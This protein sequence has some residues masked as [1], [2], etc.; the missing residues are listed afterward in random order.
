MI[1]VK[2][3]GV[4]HTVVFTS[5]RSAINHNLLFYWSRHRRCRG[6]QR[7]PPYTAQQCDSGKVKFTAEATGK[8]NK[9]NKSF[10]IAT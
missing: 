6:V 9:L 3:I 7:C 5:S 2:E 4:E 1:P 8:K 10:P